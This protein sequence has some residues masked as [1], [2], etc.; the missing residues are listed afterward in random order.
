MQIKKDTE[1][2]TGPSLHSWWGGVKEQRVIAEQ[3]NHPTDPCRGCWKD[4]AGH[5]NGV[6]AIPDRDKMWSHF[7]P[8]IG[9]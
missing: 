8:Y 2:A 4:I 6:S 5:W 1:R 9:G 7:G 3:P